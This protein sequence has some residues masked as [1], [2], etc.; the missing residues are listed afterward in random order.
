M[1]AG[2]GRNEGERMERKQ[3]VKQFVAQFPG[4]YYLDFTVTARLGAARGES[5]G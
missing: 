1:G 3:Q 4:A 5:P 2:G